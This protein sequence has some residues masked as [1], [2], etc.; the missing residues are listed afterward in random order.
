MTATS[1]IARVKI[2]VTPLMIEAARDTGLDCH[3]WHDGAIAEMYRAMRALE[4]SEHVG[5]P[6]LQVWKAG[7]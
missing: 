1:P 3:D 4:P 7:R 6:E 5:V 2:E